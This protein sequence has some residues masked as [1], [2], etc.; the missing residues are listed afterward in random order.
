[1]LGTA[2]GL[3]VSGRELDAAAGLFAGGLV[4]AAELA[5]WAL[6]PGAAVPLGRAATA[7]RALV[8]AVVVLA[9]T[10]GGTVLVLL[11]EDPV[12][13]GAALGVAGI[14]GLGAILVLAAVLARSLRGDD[15]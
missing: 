9:A 3:A 12:R 11:V 13:G 6:E 4:L 5:F 10:I 14:A 2:Y 8:V 1:M 7:R 15:R